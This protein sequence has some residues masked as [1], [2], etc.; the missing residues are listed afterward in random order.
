MARR[1]REWE[2][3]ATGS[4]EA[5]ACLG[6]RIGPRCLPGEPDDCGGTYAEHAGAHLCAL[7]AVAEHQL[8]HHLRWPDD[9]ARRMVEDVAV[10]LDAACRAAHN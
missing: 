5:L 2:V 4:R 7:I 8:Q 10:E 3:A 9:G 1:D 6:Y